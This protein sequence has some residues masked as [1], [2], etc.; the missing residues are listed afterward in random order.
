MGDGAG[1]GITV[2]LE[3]GSGIPQA[4]SGQA[5]VGDKDSERQAARPA[6]LAGALLPTAVQQGRR[7]EATRA[8]LRQQPEVH[9][10]VNRQIE[11]RSVT[12][13]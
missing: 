11:R 1:V 2:P 4:R 7:R 12:V 5:E 9:G 10:T 8:Q 13:T 3:K 6:E